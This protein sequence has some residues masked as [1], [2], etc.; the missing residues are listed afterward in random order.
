M[1]PAVPSRRPP[2][3]PPSGHV[4]HEAALRHLARF[5]A[6][7]A[8]LL[9]VLD[10]RIARWA[11]RMQDDGQ[12]VPETTLREAREAAATVVSALAAEGLVDDAAFAAAR[13]RRLSRGG[14]SG[15]AIAAS[16]AR[17][18]VGETEAREAVADDA[19]AEF[20][21][22]VLAARRRR[23]G[24]FAPGAG[25][26]PDEAAPDDPRVLGWFARAGFTRDVAQR[27]LALSPEEAAERVLAARR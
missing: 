5:A 18:G 3:P 12:V 8:G 9:R 21:R 16:L 2:G 10:R 4:L 14:R 27:V 24:P 13:A 11:R 15:R 17:A 26:E 1:P 19:E 25:V 7:R 6:T 22:A 20:D 23:V